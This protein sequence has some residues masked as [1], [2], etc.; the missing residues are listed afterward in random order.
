MYKLSPL[1]DRVARIREKY[2][3]T[4]PSICTARYRIVTEFYQENPQLQGILKRAKNFKSI[5][6]KLPVLI[7]EDEVIVGWQ[8]AKYRAC[9]LYPETSFSWFLDE[10]KAGTIPLRD[11]DPY[12]IDPEDVE[13]ILSTGDFWRK[14]C[15]SAKVDEYIPPG[16][17]KAA[18]NG[19][20]T[21][22]VKDTCTSP[23]G[24]FTANFEKAM[25][26]G[27]GAIKAEAQQKMDKLEGVL[28]GNNVEKYNF[29][30]AVTIVCDGMITLSRRYGQEC[31]RLAAIEQNPARK[32]ELLEM[33]DCLNWIMANPCRSFHDAL[34]CMFL[35]QIGLC[36][37]AQQHGIS[38]GRVDQYLG[39]FY[40]ADIAQG[41]ISHSRAQELLDLFYLKVAEMNKIWPYFATLSGP[42]YTSGQLMTI[43]GVTRDGKDATNPVS[44]MM[45]QSAGRLVLHDPPQSLR[46]HKGTPPE[47]WEAAVE[48]TRIAGGVPTFENDDVIIPALMARGL[49]LESARNYCLIGC[50]EP[51]GCGDE[52][53]C[54]GGNGTEAFFNLANA[55]LLAINNGCNPMPDRHGKRSGQTGLPTG[56]LYEMET[57][58][59]VLDAVKKQI[60]YFAAWHVSLVNTFEYVASEHMQLPLLSATIDGCME[61]GKDVMKGGAKYNS[62][63]NAAIAIG[64]ITDSLAV[65]KHMVYDKKLISAR[66]LYDAI[67][68]NWEG[69]EDL[70]QTIL[71]EAPHYGN[72]NEYVD[73]FARWVSDVYGNAINSA[74]GPR[75]RWAAGLFPV[76]AHVLFGMFTGATPDGRKA[77]E[78]LSDGISPVQ[79]LDRNGPTAIIKSVSAIDQKKFSN[80]TLLNMRFHPSALSNET[81]KE[82]LIALIKT[83]FALGGMELQFNVVSAKTLKDAQANPKDYRDL[84][85]RIAGFSAYFV[86]LYKA[87][88]DDIIKRT[89]LSL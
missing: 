45:L 71:N 50:V 24:H 40:E 13:Y 4:R 58:D 51:Q 55:F 77:G 23:I 32:K 64:N 7:N 70:R 18:G 42:G 34:Q 65:V 6:E 52:W 56:Y 59:Q 3:T 5:C 67:M 31:E 27:F 47:L 22:G 68:S 10:L 19:V 17:H 9:A 43:G 69:K 74:T 62:T 54:P 57:F 78:P 87:S 38:F 85:V 79:Q 46:I 12:D 60:E 88:Q 80:G 11:V 29:Y 16:Y 49:P 21:F 86:E 81:G 33:A 35:Y 8:A 53:A 73:V 30:R 44:F 41:R 26:K 39:S 76:T 15:L 89:E 14:E 83:Y 82:K 84:V 20:T 37:D 61:S 48:T 28:F 36:L 1:T 2:R 66:E 75:G 72:D 25:R 63:G